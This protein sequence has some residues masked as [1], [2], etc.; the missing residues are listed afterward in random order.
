M[1]GIAE[2]RWYSIREFCSLDTP[3]IMFD[4]N[5]DYVVLRL[6]QVSFLPLISLVTGDSFDVKLLPMSFGPDQLP[7]PGAPGAV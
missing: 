2:R 7:R 3:I 1:N 4:K 5:E 6:K